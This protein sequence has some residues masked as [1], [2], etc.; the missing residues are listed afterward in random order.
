M[1]LLL[2]LLPVLDGSADR[3]LFSLSSEVKDGKCALYTNDDVV[4]ERDEQLRQ[5]L[6]ATAAGKE[7]LQGQSHC[8]LL[9]LLLF[10]L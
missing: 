8:L 7:N 1:H 6:L 10:S 5:Q 4:R 9:F 2:M 3:M